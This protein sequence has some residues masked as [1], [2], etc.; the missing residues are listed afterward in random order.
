M[1]ADILAA[2]E[3]RYEL[4]G[5]LTPLC[6]FCRAPLESEECRSCEGDE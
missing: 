4:D 6:P 3:V 5:T 1:E 2:I